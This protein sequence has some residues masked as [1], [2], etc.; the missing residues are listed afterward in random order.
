MLDDHQ[1][2]RD[3]LRGAGRQG[4]PRRRH[5]PRVQQALGR[6]RSVIDTFLAE[7]PEAA[8]SLHISAQVVHKR[9]PQTMSRHLTIWP[10]LQDAEPVEFRFGTRPKFVL[11]LRI[12]RA[13]ADG[14]AVTLR[15]AA[16]SE[17]AAG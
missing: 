3:G 13:L 17:L 5:T 8:P 7:D 10:Y 11:N 16:N 14:A 4:D 9:T 15:H 6:R 12:A 1:P 2:E